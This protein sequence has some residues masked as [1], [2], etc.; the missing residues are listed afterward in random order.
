M[1]KVTRIDWTI[2]TGAQWWSGTNDTVKIEILGD[3]GLVKRLN[4]EPGLTPRLDRSEFA[5]YWWTFQSPDGSASAFPVPR[6]HIRRTFPRA[7]VVT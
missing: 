6:F 1:S 7:S 3:G 2:Q 5:T 4:L